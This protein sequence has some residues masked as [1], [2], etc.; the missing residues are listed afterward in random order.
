MEQITKAKSNNTCILYHFSF[1]NVFKGS[2]ISEGEMTN[3]ICLKQGF[4]LLMLRILLDSSW[5]SQGLAYN[6]Q[7]QEAQIIL[8]QKSFS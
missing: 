3:C 8:I 7:L 5:R 2:Q 1:D 6:V 4:L